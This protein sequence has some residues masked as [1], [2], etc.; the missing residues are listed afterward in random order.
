[1][2]PLDEPHVV[3]PP[4]DP[5][6]EDFISGRVSTEPELPTPPL[7]PPVVTEESHDVPLS[8]KA[9]ESR[10]KSPGL[11]TPAPNAAPLQPP[12][13][14]ASPAQPAV[15]VEARS[16]T[17]ATPGPEGDPTPE[18][19][20]RGAPQGGTESSEQPPA[21]KPGWAELVVVVVKA[22]RSLAKAL[23][24]L[25]DRKTALMLM[26][27]LLS[28]DTLLMEEHYKKKQEQRGPA[29]RWGHPDRHSDRYSDDRTDCWVLFGVSWG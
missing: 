17:T 11:G 13:H 2:Q 24:P 9:L 12:S 3:A 25:A 28:E 21:G 27:Q 6:Q 19:E 26:E 16:E 22:D 5:N 4:P 14:A 23:Y 20:E 10:S 8:D 29:Q 7:P 1:M 15:D 18:V